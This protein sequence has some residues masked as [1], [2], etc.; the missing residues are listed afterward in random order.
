MDPALAAQVGEEVADKVLQY[1]QDGSGWKI[2]REERSDNFLEAIC[3]VS[4]EPT[5]CVTRTATPSAVMNLIS[6]RDFVDLVL[7]KTYK[8]G[9]ISSNAAHLEHP[10]YPPQ[11]GYVRGRNHP[12]GCFCEPVLGEPNKTRVVTFFQ[13]DLSGLLPQSVVDAFFPRSMAGF[14]AN[15]QKALR[16][17]PAPTEGTQDAAPFQ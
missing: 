10:S 6:P 2:C 11:P 14:Y 13:T 4:R 17:T 9:T 3:G 8:D 16:R 12:C 7:V 1:R 15:L 5:L